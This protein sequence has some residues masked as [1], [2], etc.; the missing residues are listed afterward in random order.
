MNLPKVCIIIPTINEAET[1][2]RVIDEIPRQT[3]EQAGYQVEVMVFDGGSTVRTRQIAEEFDLSQSTIKYWL[4]K[5]DLK[6][7]FKTPSEGYKCNKCGET[8]QSKFY[9]S[10]RW[11]CSAC[12]NAYKIEQA[13]KKREFALS[14]L[15]AECVVCGYKKFMCS[16]DIHHIDPKKKL[17]A[18]NKM[19][20]SAHSI[21]FIKKEIKK[22]KV[23]CG[24][25]H[26]K[27]HNKILKL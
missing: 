23:L 24:N 5:Y 13:K 25:C 11:L 17:Y 20:H 2:G 18:I 19:A 6:T 15:G 10:Q 21:P 9:K 22:C 16:L 7:A 4:K 14:I 3:L 8:K 26:R 12:F 27:V 1:I